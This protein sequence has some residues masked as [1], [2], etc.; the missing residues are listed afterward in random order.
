MKTL[1]T[2]FLVG[3]GIVGAAIVGFILLVVGG[4][5]VMLFAGPNTF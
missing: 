2:G 1:A 4:T 5:V 3:L